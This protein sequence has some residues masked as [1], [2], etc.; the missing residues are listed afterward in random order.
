MSHV[1]Y[2]TD[3][4]STQLIDSKYPSRWQPWISGLTEPPSDSWQI[5]R[6]SEGLTATIEA[7]QRDH[8]LRYFHR[9]PTDEQWD[10]AAAGK[11]L[12]EVDPYSGRA[13][14]DFY[15][16]DS[17]VHVRSDTSTRLVPR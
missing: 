3:S 9:W 11:S 15:A 6:D 5:A 7:D 16:Y 14:T 2:D 4:Q 8:W 12:E 13:I 17:Y 10:L 1:V